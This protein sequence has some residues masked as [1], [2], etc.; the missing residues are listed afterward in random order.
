MIERVTDVHS[1]P[2]RRISALGRLVAAVAMVVALGCGQADAPADGGAAS[3]RGGEVEPQTTLTILFASDDYVLGPSRD[4]SPKF[5]MFEPLVRGYGTRAR[6]GLAER[7]EHSGDFRTWTYH[8]RR[9]VRWHDGVPFTAHDVAFS[10]ELFRKP[11]IALHG[12]ALMIDSIAVPDE[13]TLV[14]TF[15]RP[16]GPEEALPGWPVFYPKHLLTDLDPTSFFDWEF[17][18]RPVGNGPYRYVRGVSNT[19]IETQA[20]PDYF[21]GT[22]AIDRVVLRLSSANKVTELRSGNVDV[23][24]YL[25][26]PE[27]AALVADPRFRVYFQWITSEPQAIHWNQ[28][29]PFLAHALVRRA[30]SHAVNRRELARLLYLPDEMPLVGG[31]SPDDR[32]LDLYREGKLDQGFVFDPRAAGELLDEA[33]WLDRGGD[34]VRERA[35]IEAR[36]TLL[37]RQGGILSTLE[38]ALLLQNQLRRVGVEVEIRPVESSVWWELFRSGDFDATVHDVRNVPTDLLREG[39]FGE[40]T[41]IGYRNPEIVRLLEALTLELTSP[42]QDTLYARINAILRRDVPVTFLFP[43]F[44]AYAA[45]RK[46]RGLRT[47]DHSHPIEAIQEVWIEDDGVEP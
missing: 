21:E 28:R 15:L 24:Y 4:D 45:H 5:L 8:L 35:G 22:P 25:S 17:W 40:G 12:F 29:H 41:K 33:G 39:F 30:L 36:F 38:P 32:A 46:V 19:M 3:R 7:W 2:R 31:L 26:A 27:I 1:K 14:L 37:A 9:D 6:P 47:P 11:E 20:N 16:T 42:G 10:L 34:G 18:T 13:H 23:A 43:Y 44:E